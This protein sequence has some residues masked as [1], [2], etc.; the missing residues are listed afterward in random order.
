MGDDTL[1][2]GNGEYRVTQNTKF[3]TSKQ[4][5]DSIQNIDFEASNG[6]AVEVK[7]KLFMEQ[8][9]R[10]A[11][12]VCDYRLVFFVSSTLSANDS[13]LHF[14]VSITPTKQSKK[15]G[16]FDRILMTYDMPESEQVFGLG[17][18]FSVWSL[19]GHKIPVI[20]REQG[21]ARGLQ[22]VTYVLNN[23]PSGAYAG[24]DAYSTYTATSHYITS[25]SRSMSLFTP[26]LSIFDFTQKQSATVEV[27]DTDFYGVLIHGLRPLDLVKSYTH[28]LKSSN[29]TSPEFDFDGSGRMT[30]LPNWITGSEG[31]VIGIQGGEEKVVRVLEA[32]KKWKVPVA[33]IW[34]QDWVGTREQNIDASFPIPVL[35]PGFPAGSQVRLNVRSTSSQKRLWWNWEYCRERYPNWKTFVP[36]IK[37]EYNVRVMTYIN[38]FLSDVAKGGKPPASWSRNY[39]REASTLG[40]LVKRWTLEAKP[41]LVDYD[42]SSGPG[43]DAGMVDLTNPQACIW[44]KNLIKQN[45]LADGVE[46]WMADFG[47][48]LPHDSSIYAQRNKNDSQRTWD[49]VPSDYHNWYP[50]EW[51]KLNAEAV[52]E[53]EQENNIK[54]NDIVFFSRSASRDSPRFSRAFWNG[55]QIPTWDH[56]DGLEST[57]FA[58][59]SQGMSGMAY[60]HSDIGGYTTINVDP[61]VN[62]TAGNKTT[63]IF[64][65]IIANRA[66]YIRNDRQLFYRWMESAAFLSTA[67]FRVHEGSAPDENLQIWDDQKIASA[68]GYYTSMWQTLKRYRA[69]LTDEHT[70]FGYPPVRPAHFHYPQV[71]QVFE[72]ERLQFMLGPL[73]F[74]VPV[75]T[76][77]TT[78]LND[79]LRNDPR[80]DDPGDDDDDFPFPEI[81]QASSAYWFRRSLSQK[82]TRVITSLINFVS[83]YGGK[84][85]IVAPSEN[86]K[87]RHGRAFLPPG[88]WMHVWTKENITTENGMFITGA[89]KKILC[90]VGLPPVFVRV[91]S[92]GEMDKMVASPLSFHDDMTYWTG[93]LISENSLGSATDDAWNKYQLMLKSLEPFLAFTSREP[94]N[95]LILSNNVLENKKE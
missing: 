47:E 20:T 94:S 23:R 8:L 78:N 89:T 14:K 11:V 79:V 68:F 75:T 56:L 48:Y 93:D 54:G 65:P 43:V 85:T 37:K 13:R 90:P 67:M 70:E 57:I 29:E 45:M 15:F 60:T 12:H 91:F 64:L 7:G 46:G 61:N 40:Y 59:L 62:L 66:R 30:P 26:A 9:L 4:S 28:R 34:L 74:V 38:P 36:R 72:M 87:A 69:L 42:V 88:T 16:I 3:T 52:A 39:Y 95:K 80:T 22:P 73:L 51:A 63:S 18:Q 1:S 19:R 44:F 49:T 10:P 32:L 41:V 53:Y 27:V 92:R 25:M 2:P 21:V 50:R 55:D 17:E 77:G 5:I 82:V 58:T 33:A 76:P 31:A 83:T 86:P 71:Q 24:A 35:I 6:G 81:G 84:S